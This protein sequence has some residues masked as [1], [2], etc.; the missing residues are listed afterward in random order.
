MCSSMKNVALGVT[1]MLSIGLQA[2]SKHYAFFNSPGN[3]SKHYTENL[4]AH[5]R[6]TGNK[7]LESLYSTASNTLTYGSLESIVDVFANSTDAT[8]DTRM[9]DTIDQGTYVVFMTLVVDKLIARYYQLLDTLEGACQYW[10]WAKT[11]PTRYALSQSPYRWFTGSP[12]SV[13]AEGQ[14]LYA[15]QLREKYAAEFGAL[16]RLLEAITENTISHDAWLSE[17]RK[18]LQ[19][20]LVIGVAGDHQFLQGQ[21]SLLQQIVEH[22]KVICDAVSTVA[23]PHWAKRNWITLAS[24]ATVAAILAYEYY[25]HQ[26]AVDAYIVATMNSVNNGWDMYFVKPTIELKDELQR[27]LNPQA[28]KFNPL[29]DNGTQADS[30]VL[31][32]P[33]A[34]DAGATAAGPEMTNQQK[35]Q[36]FSDEMHKQLGVLEKDMKGSSALFLLCGGE[37]GRTALIKIMRMIALGLVNTLL[38]VNDIVTSN[39][40]TAKIV[41][42]FISYL[43]LK[44]TYDTGASI[45]GWFTKKDRHMLVLRLRQAQDLLIRATYD[46]LTDGEYGRLLYLLMKEYEQVDSKVLA[47]ERSLFV[48]DL[49]YLTKAQ[50]SIAQKRETISVMFDKYKSL[51]RA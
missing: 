39:T 29:T 20:I 30:T 16:S 10:E 17:L 46:Q 47:D 2:S 5:V 14:S 32:N 7:K 3:R 40:L 51:A 19:G 49:N 22:E 31:A 21:R 4:I 25:A 36:A 41:P 37:A 24:G 38:G 12:F 9:L 42:A 28:V 50:P 8:A 26:P 33:I 45:Y 15:Q 27:T 6:I 23:M 48:D 11:H 35:N 1:L 34:S 13:E 43:A 18:T 44:K